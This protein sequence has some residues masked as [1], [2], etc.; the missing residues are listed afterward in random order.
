MRRRRWAPVVQKA[1]AYLKMY[2]VQREVIVA[3][4]GSSDGSQTIAASLGA[5]VVPVSS[6]GYGSSHLADSQP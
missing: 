4:N 5:R 3:D 6:R 1:L 2:N